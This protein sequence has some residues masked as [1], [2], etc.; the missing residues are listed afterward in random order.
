M[1][2][3]MVKRMRDMMTEME[4]G[5]EQDAGTVDGGSCGATSCEY[6][7]SCADTKEAN[8]TPTP[9]DL[10]PITV[11]S[12]L[13]NLWARGAKPGDVPEHRIQEC[14]GTVLLAMDCHGGNRLVQVLRHHRVGVGLLHDGKMGVPDRVW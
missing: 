13:Y 10:R 9:L 5:G 8:H 4:E 7:C 12:L 11:T 1:I 3:G 14:V 2:P 6:G